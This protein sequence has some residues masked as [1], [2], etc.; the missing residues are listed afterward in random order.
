MQLT[1]IG[2]LFVSRILQLHGTAE[3]KVAIGKPQKL[4]DGKDYYC[5]YQIIGLGDGKVNWG[6]GQDAPPFY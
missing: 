4:P 1:S 5:P 2:E 6:G 3:V